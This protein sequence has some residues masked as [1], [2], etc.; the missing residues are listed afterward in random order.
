MAREIRQ[1]HL[2]WQMSETHSYAQLEFQELSQHQHMLLD[3]VCLQMY[4]L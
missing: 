3:L 4:H 1:T 2:Q